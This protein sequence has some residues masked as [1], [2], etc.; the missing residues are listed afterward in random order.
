LKNLC[1]PCEFVSLLE[2]NVLT[3]IANIN[4]L[5]RQSGPVAPHFCAWHTYAIAVIVAVGRQFCRVIPAGGAPRDTLHSLVFAPSRERK[6]RS[7]CV[8]FATKHTL[9]S[10]SPRKNERCFLFTPR[11]FSLLLQGFFSHSQSKR[12]FS[13]GRARDSLLIRKKV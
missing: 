7:V 1:E 3:Q 6:E 5:L 2:S 13:A 8:C 12:H 4:S 9:I 11:H 10:Y